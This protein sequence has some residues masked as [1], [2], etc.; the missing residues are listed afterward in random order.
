VKVA[1]HYFAL[2]QARFLD[3]EWLRASSR[4][5][6]EA[7]VRV[8]LVN[9]GLRVL[10]LYPS[11]TTHTGLF[12]SVESGGGVTV[13]ERSLCPHR[14]CMVV[15]GVDRS[16]RGQHQEWCVSRLLGQTPPTGS[17]CCAGQVFERLAG[18]VA[19]QAAHDLTR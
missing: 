14:R 12:R 13:R 7:F 6:P 11:R 19:F 5:I 4:R 16:L 2:E 3:S 18:D 15:G 9:R 8:V 1:K 17:S 10:G